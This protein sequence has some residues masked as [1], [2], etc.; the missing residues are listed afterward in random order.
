VS[1]RRL[2]LLVVGLLFV[3]ALLPQRMSVYGPPMRD[4]L[5]RLLAPVASP[6]TNLSTRLRPPP[7]PPAR[8]GGDVARLSAEL[9]QRD[10]MILALQRRVETLETAIAQLQDLKRRV[11]DAYHF[12]SASVV[13][14]SADPAASTVHLD[15]GSIEGVAPFMAVVDGGHLL[16]RVVQAGKTTSSVAPLAALADIQLEVVFTPPDLPEIGLP[17]ERSRTCLL[18]PAGRDR[19][20]EEVDKA[21]PVDVGDFARLSDRAGDG[22]WPAAAQGMIIGRVARVEPHPEDPLRKRVEVR[23][24]VSLRSLSSVT[25]LVPRVPEQSP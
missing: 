10:G 12:R 8:A 19:F 11:G 15:I 5:I 1:T 13:G 7:E 25:I 16:G 6:L 21:M 2:V 23:P 4:L 22:A 20:I 17:P 18:R 14:R 3:L 24:V 9:N